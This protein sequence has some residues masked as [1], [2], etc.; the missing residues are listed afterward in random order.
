MKEP[1]LHNMGVKLAYTYNY[2]IMRLNEVGYT[3]LLR[4]A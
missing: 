2:M 4:S 3:M 1:W